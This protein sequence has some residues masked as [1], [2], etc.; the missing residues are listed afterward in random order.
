MPSSANVDREKRALH[1]VW[2]AGLH[3]A[4]LPRNV[5]LVQTSASAIGGGALKTQDQNDKRGW[6]FR[7]S[8]LLF[9]QWWK[10]L[11]W[12]FYPPSKNSHCQGTQWS[13]QGT[14]KSRAQSIHNFGVYQLALC[15]F[16]INYHSHLDRVFPYD[17]SIHQSHLL[18][19][20]FPGFQK[21]N[22]MLICHLG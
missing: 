4:P 5:K 18:H 17:L 9:G 10:G 13:K 14:Q 11:H 8:L 2:T 3:Q 16:V 20:D 1:P 15:G 7:Y 19:E 6:G 21:F 22:I 12:P